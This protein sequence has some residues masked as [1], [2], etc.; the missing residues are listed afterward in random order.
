MHDPTETDEK[1]EMTTPEQQN[2]RQSQM[3]NT[4]KDIHELQTLLNKIIVK[5]SPLSL[6]LWKKHKK[7]I[8]TYLLLIALGIYCLV[9]ISV[10][11]FEKAKDLFIILVVSVIIVIYVSIRDAFGKQITTLVIEPANRKIQEHWGIFR[12]YVLLQNI[13]LSSGFTNVFKFAYIC[14]IY[15]MYGYIAYVRFPGHFV[16]IIKDHSENYIFYI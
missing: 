7:I 4:P 13:F 1:I 10:A 16:L 14:V 9:G 15:S 2:P 8:L 6:L 3:E 12:W 11:G 5:H